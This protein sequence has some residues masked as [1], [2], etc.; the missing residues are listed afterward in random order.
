MIERRKYRRVKDGVRVIYKVLGVNGETPTRALDVAAGGLRLPVKEK[1][2][3]GALLELGLSL[4]EDKQPF[5]CLT[6]VVWQADEVK[7]DKHG[8]DYYETGMEFV[9]IDIR[10]RMRLIHYVYPLLRKQRNE[11]GQL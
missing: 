3:P 9:R 2:K 11:T 6:R 8:E 5:F 4:P 7:R 10:Q 1:I